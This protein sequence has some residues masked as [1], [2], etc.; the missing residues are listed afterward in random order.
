MT[1]LA[2]T[3]LCLSLALG[4]SAQ[5]EA[6]RNPLQEGETWD[7]LRSDILN[8]NKAVTPGSIFSVEAPY[9]AHDAATVPVVITQTDQSAGPIRTLKLVVDENPAPLAAEIEFGPAMAPLNFET[10]VRVNSYSNLRVVAETQ[11]ASYIDGRFVKASGGC[12]APATRDPEV[13]LAHMGEMR[14][15]HFDSAPVQAGVRRDAQLMIRHP[16]Y[17]GLQR[18][19][20]TQLFVPAHFI[21]DLTVWQGDDVLFSLTGGISISEDPVFRFSYTD[22]GAPDLRIRAEDTDGNVFEQVLPKDSAS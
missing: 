7:Y 10:R 20:I 2:L 12:A 6:P 19:Q 15:R 17:S 14:L 16:N 21:Q 22:N 8:D 18:D 11:N 3:A 5:A 1:R 4:T 13:A 9:R